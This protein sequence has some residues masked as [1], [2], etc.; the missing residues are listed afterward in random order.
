M[1]YI[2]K[3]RLTSLQQEIMHFFF[4]NAGRMFNARELAISLGVS[5]PAISKALPSLEN[6]GFVHV[7]KD[8][9]SK[10]FSTVMKS[11]KERLERF[12]HFVPWP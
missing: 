8:R 12:F 1:V 3:L 9:K 2:S 4:V 7:T 11:E 5:Q 6:K 10:R